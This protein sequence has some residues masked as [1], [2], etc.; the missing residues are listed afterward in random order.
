MNRE[1]LIEIFGSA[2]ANFSEVRDRCPKNR[3]RYVYGSNCCSPDIDCDSLPRPDI[4]HNGDIDNCA[5][6][7]S[8]LC[9][10]YESGTPV[11][12]PFYSAPEDSYR[13]ISSLIDSQILLTSSRQPFINASL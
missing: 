8:D 9:L 7:Q 11:I 10:F 1:G 13:L 6:N 3:Q 5:R 4:D 12:A 2:G